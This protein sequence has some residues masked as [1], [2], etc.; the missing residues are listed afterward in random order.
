VSGGSAAPDA[1]KQYLEYVAK[2]RPYVTDQ[3]KSFC[4]ST[5]R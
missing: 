2:L 5:P 4:A 1:A 3:L